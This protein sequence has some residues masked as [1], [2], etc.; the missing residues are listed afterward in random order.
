LPNQLEKADQSM[1]ERTDCS[2]I[3][4]AG[5]IEETVIPWKQLCV[6]MYKK[7]I[8]VYIGQSF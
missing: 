8:K 2:A 3:Y 4:A 7:I 6:Y 1:F 5:S